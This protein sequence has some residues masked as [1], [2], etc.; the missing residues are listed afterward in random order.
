MNGE[1]TVGDERWNGVGECYSLWTFMTFINF[2]GLFLQAIRGVLGKVS[3]LT[4]LLGIGW[5]FKVI[6]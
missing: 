2:Y 3:S 6:F 1:M 4:T 5:G